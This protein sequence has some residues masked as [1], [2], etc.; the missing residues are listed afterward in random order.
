MKTQTSITP[1]DAIEA[2][3]LLQEYL[4]QG[5]H[6]FDHAALERVA[7]ALGEADRIVIEDDD[8]EP[9]ED[10][11]QPPEPPEEPPYCDACGHY[12]HERDSLACPFT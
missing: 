4:V 12:G 3:K 6:G 9:R 10:H 11:H 1:A 8:D 5:G 7:D 2:R